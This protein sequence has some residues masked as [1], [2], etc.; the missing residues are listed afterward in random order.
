MAKR[1]F[2]LKTAQPHSFSLFLRRGLDFVGNPMR[3]SETLYEQTKAQM[4][5][6]RR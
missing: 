6:Q 5:S 3:N 4:Q 1:C 2:S